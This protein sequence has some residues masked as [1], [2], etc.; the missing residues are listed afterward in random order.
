MSDNAATTTMT[1]GVDFASTA[2]NTAACSIEWSN[3]HANIVEF[4]APCDDGYLL[5][6]AGRVTKLGIDVPLG[7]PS[8]FVEAISMHNADGSWPTSYDHQ[9]NLSDYRYRK[10]DTWLHDELKFPLPL[11]ASTDRIAIPTMRAA[12]LVVRIAPHVNLDGSGLVVEVYP[13]SALARWGF[14]SR[15]YKGKKNIDARRALTKSFF[16]ETSSWLSLSKEH[17]ELC[18]SNDNVF[19]SVIAALVSRASLVKL[20]EPIPL[21]LQEAAKREGWIAIPREGTLSQLASPPEA[22]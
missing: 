20:I 2:A 21:N 3:G 11:S 16:D 14:Q 15:Q 22:P 10:T 17:R 5:D 13:A 18:D 9:M 12:A 19:D 4:C 6:L 1:A 8:P 7:W